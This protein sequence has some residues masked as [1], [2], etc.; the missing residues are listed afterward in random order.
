MM[1]SSADQRRAQLVVLQ[2]VFDDRP[3]QGG[4]LGDAQP[5]RHVA[6]GEIAHHDFQRDDLGHA[7]QLF[8]H[9]DAADEMGGHADVVQAR[10]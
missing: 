7:H 6:G 9:V 10:T 5:L 8:A 4:A 3:R 1:C 2:V